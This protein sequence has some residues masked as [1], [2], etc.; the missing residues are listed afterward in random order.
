MANQTARNI[1]RKKCILSC[2]FLDGRSDNSSVVGNH[3]GFS[4][5]AVGGWAWSSRSPATWNENPRV[6]SCSVVFKPAKGRLR[7]TSLSASAAKSGSTRLLSIGTN[8]SSAKCNMARCY[9]LLR[10][11]LALQAMQA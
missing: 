8:A 10:K 2:C 3:F 9:D 5:T 7:S 1:V 4:A 11:S 6:P